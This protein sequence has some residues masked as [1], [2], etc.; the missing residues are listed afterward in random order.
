MKRQEADDQI[1]GGAGVPGDA[2]ASYLIEMIT[3]DDAEVRMPKDK[4]PLDEAT[5]QK[6]RD[7]INAGLPWEPGFTFAARD[8]EPPLRPRRA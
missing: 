7:W 6:L 1:E 2:D 8:F 5:V 3:T 4:P